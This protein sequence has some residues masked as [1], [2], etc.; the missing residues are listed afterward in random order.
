MDFEF[1]CYASDGKIK[2][3]LVEIK[4]FAETQ[5]P[6]IPK[7]QTKG[8]IERVH[9]YIKNQAKWS[10]ATQYCADQRLLG[11]PFEFMIVTEKDGF[12]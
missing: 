2:E 10:A 1:R 6:A 8:Y 3:Y 11:R 7:R 5:K 9:T 4:P 12:F